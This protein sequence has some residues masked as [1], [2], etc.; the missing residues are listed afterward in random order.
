MACGPKCVLA[1]DSFPK[2]NVKFENSTNAWVPATAGFCIP[3]RMQ[4]VAGDG[5]PNGGL[6]PLPVM[7]A[8]PVTTKPSETGGLNVGHFVFQLMGSVGSVWIM[9]SVMLMWCVCGPSFVGSWFG[10]VFAKSAVSM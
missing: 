6:P 4:I 9:P 8:V 10:S 5:L 7:Y 2:V 1:R 3:P